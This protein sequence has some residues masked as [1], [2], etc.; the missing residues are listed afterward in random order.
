VELV[1]DRH[2]RPRSALLEVYPH[3]ALLELL[4]VDRRVPYKVARSNRY[5]R[6]GRLSREERIRRLLDEWHKIVDALTHDLGPLPLSIPQ[7]GEVKTLSGLKRWEDALDAII[8]AWMGA[9]YLDH[10]A[11]PYGD[12]NAAIWGP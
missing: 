1:T 11:T 9:R 7:A 6:E 5:W 4:E 10:N 8:C 2:V 12:H 3:I